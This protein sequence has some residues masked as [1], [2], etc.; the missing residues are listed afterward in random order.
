VLVNLTDG[1]NPIVLRAADALG[2]SVEVTRWVTSH[3]TP[4]SLALDPQPPSVTEVHTIRLT[5]S[6]EPGAIVTVNGVA[7]PVDGE[8]RFQLPLLL[9]RGTTRLTVVST[10]AFGNSANVSFEVTL[11]PVPP[12][13]KGPAPSLLPWLS[14]V[15]LAVL[16]IEGVVLALWARRRRRLAA[17]AEQTGG[18]DAA[19]PPP[20]AG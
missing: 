7:V 8:G 18:T 5:G 19:S 3:S 10:D 11:A 13:V 12:D 1:E 15:T 9:A 17:R 2:N 4:P 16:A 6:T 20:R 14:L